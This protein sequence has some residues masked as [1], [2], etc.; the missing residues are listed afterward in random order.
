M[1]RHLTDAEKARAVAKLG[2]I[3]KIVIENYR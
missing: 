3:L 2:E 1:P